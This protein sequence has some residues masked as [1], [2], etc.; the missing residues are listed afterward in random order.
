M[1]Y[2]MLT[3][4]VSEDKFQHSY[5]IID[6]NLC[7]NYFYFLIII[8]V[9]CRVALRCT[10]KNYLFFYYTNNLYTYIVRRQK[11]NK[12]QNEKKK[13]LKKINQIGSKMFWN[14]RRM[15]LL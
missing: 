5:A 3:S 14:I 8:R 6:T 4:A 7:K 2:N 9:R 1:L 12:I 11:L 13:K 15:H 10:H